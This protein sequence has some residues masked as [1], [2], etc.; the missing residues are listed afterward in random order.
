MRVTTYDIAEMC[1]VSQATVDRALNNRSSIKAETKEKILRVAQEM[2]YRPNSL[3]TYLKT[4]STKSIGV[5]LPKPDL[6]Y[7]EL[8]ARFTKICKLYGYHVCISFSDFNVELEKEYLA[9]FLSANMDGIIIFPV[10]D[11]GNEIK[12]IIDSGIP[13][14][15]LIRRIKNY[16]FDFVSSNYSHISKQ[17]IEYLINLGHKNICYFTIWDTS[18]NLY[19]YNER[20]HGYKN[21]LTQN[22]IPVDYRFI[23][24]DTDDYQI[25]RELLRSDNRPTAFFCF[26][27]L[28]A[29]GLVSFLNSLHFQVP[30]D[31][32]V[33]SF[34]NLDMLKYFNPG[35]TSISYP[36]D[37]MCAKAVE[38]LLNKIRNQSTETHSYIFDAHLVIRGSCKM[39]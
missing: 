32:S 12:K 29:I 11:D 2:G 33:I 6:F 28:N 22:N 37:D 10:K 34:D 17:A 8:I 9:E 15:T 13:V 35:L 20:L 3:P 24:N 4:G 27:D 38:I 21:A 7:A 23:I 5:I 30:N 25:I 19:T 16:N 36:Y 1:E 31:F 18:A 39:L 14:V 26:N